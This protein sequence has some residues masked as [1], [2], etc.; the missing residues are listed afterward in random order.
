M[1]VRNNQIQVNVTRKKK[2]AYISFAS[3][4]NIVITLFCQVSNIQEVSQS[5]IHLSELEMFYCSNKQQY[6]FR[7]FQSK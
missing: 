6:V 5:L 1:T 3:E 2:K 7:V 4:N